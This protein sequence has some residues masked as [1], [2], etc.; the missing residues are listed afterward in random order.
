M[1]YRYIYNSK[2]DKIIFIYFINLIGFGF[3]FKI[4]N[5]IMKKKIDIYNIYIYNL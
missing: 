5:K 1:K 3:I 2:I 4:V